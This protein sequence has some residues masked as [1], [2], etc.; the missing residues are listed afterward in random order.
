MDLQDSSNATVMANQNEEDNSM[1]EDKSDPNLV[2]NMKITNSDNEM[3]NQEK[4]NNLN[5]EDQRD[6]IQNLE[7][8][9]ISEL[10]T[11]L[12]NDIPQINENTQNQV[13]I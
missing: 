12:P 3:K 7:E 11:D 10:S 13:E 5:A 2:E 4:N 9:K 8:N 6:N 1:I